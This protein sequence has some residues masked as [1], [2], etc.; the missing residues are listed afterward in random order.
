[1]GSDD[2][3]GTKGH[4]VVLSIHCRFAAFNLSASDSAV[5]PGQPRPFFVRGTFFEVSACKPGKQKIQ[6]AVHA[7]EALSH[8][9]IHGVLG[10]SFAECGHNSILPLYLIL[11]S[12]SMPSFKH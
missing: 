2:S 9:H 10:G 3:G 4:G 11:C 7:T 6:K 8:V 1:M 12:V 5:M